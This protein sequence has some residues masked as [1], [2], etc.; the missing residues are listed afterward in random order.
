MRAAAALEVGFI[1]RAPNHSDLLETLQRQDAVVLEQHHALRGDFA[2]Q[3]MVGRPVERSFLEC[4][5]GGEDGAQDAPHGCIE[6]GFIQLAVFNGIDDCLGAAGFG[7]G[8]F[9]VQPALQR[10]HPVVHGAPVGDNRALKA[11]FFFEDIHQQ[12]VVLG[13]EGAVDAVVRAHHRPGLALLDGGLES[14]QVDLAQR[15]LI[16]LG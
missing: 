2:R 1:G 3:E 11:P 8:H 16:D 4:F 13:A 5:G 12:A 10:F 14:R 9:Q 6:Q 15:A 7:S